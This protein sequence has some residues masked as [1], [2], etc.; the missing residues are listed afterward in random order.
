MWA[1]VIV[2]LAPAVEYV[3][4]FDRRCKNVRVQAFIAQ[5]AIE[6]LDEGILHRF[7]R[8][9]ELEPHVVRVRLVSPLGN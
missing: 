1:D 6:A 7:A 2:V 4:R 8:P 5:P 3:L 9:N